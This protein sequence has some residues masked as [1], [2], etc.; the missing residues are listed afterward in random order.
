MS[1]KKKKK[2]LRRPIFEEGSVEDYSRDLYPPQAPY[3][4]TQFQESRVGGW[5]ADGAI[6]S[7]PMILALGLYFMPPGF[8]LENDE[9]NKSMK[10]DKINKI[11]YTGIILGTV[12]VVWGGW[13]IF[14][15][16][17]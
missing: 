16:R 7:L 6:L 4:V 13:Y 14:R 5:A 9:R 10:S 17:K 3:E 12:G 1:K 15:Y 2:K 8:L 11:R